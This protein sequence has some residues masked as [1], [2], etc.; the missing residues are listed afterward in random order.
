[1]EMVLVVDLFDIG[2]WRWEMIEVDDGTASVE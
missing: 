1:V 2:S